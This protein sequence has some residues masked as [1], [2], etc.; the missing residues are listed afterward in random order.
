LPQPQR[1]DPLAARARQRQ[2]D[3]LTDYR[4]TR[5]KVERKPGPPAAP[6][7]RRPAHALAATATSNAFGWHGAPQGQR[8][9]LALPGRKDWLIAVLFL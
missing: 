5:P 7:P 4:A 3:W 1:A 9:G 8:R 6:P 2:P